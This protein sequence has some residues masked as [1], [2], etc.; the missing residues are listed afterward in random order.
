MYALWDRYNQ[1]RTAGAKKQ[2]NQILNTFIECFKNQTAEVRAAFVEEVCTQV[3]DAI[4]NAPDDYWLCGGYIS[5]FNLPVHIQVPFVEEVLTPELVHRLRVNAKDASTMR[6]FG[7]FSSMS[8]YEQSYAIQ[9]D[10]TTLRKIIVS[11]MKSLGYDCHEM[12]SGVLSEPE[13]MSQNVAKARD[14]LE[15]LEPST[16]KDKW[17][18][19]LLEYEQI[20]V[21]W[22]DYNKHRSLYN[23]FRHYLTVNEQKRRQSM[24]IARNRGQM[25]STDDP[26]QVLFDA[27]EVNDL[28][29]VKHC[30][31][32]GADVH[33]KNG[34]WCNTPLHLA[35]RGN[36][37]IINI[38]ISR[39]A[40][41]HSQNV[42]AETPLHW[43]VHNAN[44]KVAEYL[45]S[46]GADV[47]AKDK[48]GDTPLHV[49]ASNGNLEV[50][51]FLISQRA[52]VNVKNHHAYTPLHIAVQNLKYN[53]KFDVIAH[54]VSK[55][56]NVNAKDNGG[57]T[58]LHWVNNIDVDVI[59]FLVDKG[60]DVNI[61][62]GSGK[63]PFDLAK[64]EKNTAVIEYLAGFY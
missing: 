60:A 34:E 24:W 25:N 20:A 5:T 58:P 63:T 41:V 2:A 50:V 22:E 10:Q 9:K 43:A 61:K 6:W 29:V 21:Y 3:W 36:V 12:P 47:N 44:I 8:L 53:L 49:A 45:I 13:V 64:K 27:I 42:R 33:A 16:L 1:V 11:Y 19:R 54:L 62:N 31:E 55:G 39:G 23:D 14:Y 37:E 7:E 15:Q 51:Q 59:K 4:A 52:E 28:D 18:E 26:Q 40:D 56:A 38:L 17:N 46:S 32:R 57:N 30:I 48:W 35:T